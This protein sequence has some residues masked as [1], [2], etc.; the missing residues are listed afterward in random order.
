MA[1]P[2][3]TATVTTAKGH[4]GVTLGNGSDGVVVEAADPNDLIAKAGLAAGD[5]IISLNGESVSTHSKAMAI[6]DG[7]KGKKVVIAYRTCAEQSA[8]EAR[9]KLRAVLQTCGFMVLILA[10]LAVPFGYMAC[11]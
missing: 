11:A 4:L 10:A 7:A 2:L 8:K 1:T 6:F 5:V 9:G 3:H